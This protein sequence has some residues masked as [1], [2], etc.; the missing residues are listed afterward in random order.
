M[1]CFFSISYDDDALA[2][3][4]RKNENDLPV[5]KLVG[6]STPKEWAGE[7]AAELLLERVRLFANRILSQPAA[8]TDL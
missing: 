8:M 4:E 1:L 3:G 6:D 7:D 2:V 5:D